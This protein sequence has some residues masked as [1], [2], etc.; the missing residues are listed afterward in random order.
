MSFESNRFPSGLLRLIQIVAV[1]AVLWLLA[2]YGIVPAGTRGVMTTFGKP[3]DEVLDEGIHLRIPLAQTIHLL[4]IRVQ[5]SEGEGDA[6]SK[7]LQAVHTRVAINYHLEPHQVAQAFRAIGTSTDIIADRIILPAAQESMKA[8]T[9]RFTAEELITRRTDVREGIASLLR[10]KMQRH[11]LV[12]DEFAVINFRFSDSFSKAIEA[13][14]GAEQDKLRAERDLLRI[15]VEAEQKVTQAKA[16]AES[17]ALQRAQVTP[18]LLKLREVENQRAAIA[19]W[20]GV[21]PTTTYGQVPLI[22][23]AAAAAK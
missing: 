4:E 8:V 21:L 2:P 15:R 14:V 6:A 11:G 23:I 16:E 19:K 12:L 10:E 9:A 20:N 1:V 3:A 7:D 5:K 17:L 13:K 22:G 18:E